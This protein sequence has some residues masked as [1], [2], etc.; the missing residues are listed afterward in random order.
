MADYLTR[1]GARAVGRFAERAVEPRVP[2][3]FEG[4]GD[5]GAEQR[6][7]DE[8]ELA[9]TPSTADVAGAPTPAERS[10]TPPTVEPPSTVDA[11]S[12][13]DN[14][15]IPHDV[16]YRLTEPEPDP[17]AATLPSTAPDTPDAASTVDTPRTDTEPARTIVLQP[18]PAAEPAP[19]ADRAPALPEPPMPVIRVTIGRIEVRAAPPSQAT[20]PQVGHPAPHRAPE[21]PPTERLS[22]YLRG[23]HRGGRP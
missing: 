6:I 21:P 12:V 2:S 3:R 20:A 11:P 15:R 22:A 16:V 14:L 1:L 18:V 5:A 7:A 10:S 4:T 8:P 13:L 17:T 19:P 9:G 23:E